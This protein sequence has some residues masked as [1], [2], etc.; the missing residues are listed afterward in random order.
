MSKSGSFSEFSRQV[1]EAQLLSDIIAKLTEQEEDFL[2]TAEAASEALLC[3]PKESEDRLTRLPCGRAC[4]DRL[5]FC[6][7]VRGMTLLF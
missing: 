7:I 5:Y 4:D 1:T 6:R 3:T 2:R